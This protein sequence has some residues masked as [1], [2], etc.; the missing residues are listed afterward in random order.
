MRGQKPDNA[1]HTVPKSK[2]C[3]FFIP[4]DMEFQLL[5]GADPFLEP[6]LEA[7]RGLFSLNDL[8]YHSEHK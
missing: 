2:A 7:T 3:K 1:I 4:M 8:R 5:K 6:K